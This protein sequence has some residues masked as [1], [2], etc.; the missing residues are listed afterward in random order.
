VDPEI[1]RDLDEVESLDDGRCCQE[2]VP[3]RESAVALVCIGLVGLV[4]R[5]AGSG[6]DSSLLTWFRAAGVPGSIESSLK[7]GFGRG[8]GRRST[9][10]F[11]DWLNVEL[12][13]EFAND[14]LL[15]AVGSLGG[16]NDL[17]RSVVHVSKSGP[18]FNR[19]VQ[20]QGKT[21]DLPSE[22]V[23]LSAPGGSPPL[24][25]EYALHPPCRA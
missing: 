8:E 3:D 14:R 19:A 4:L 17:A 23:F 22:P 21:P 9:G 12:V 7:C 1:G 16:D 10:G 11:I 20:T 15:V 18:I 6:R 2:R 13:G 24:I 25:Y 5:G